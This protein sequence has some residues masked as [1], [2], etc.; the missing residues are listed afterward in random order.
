MDRGTSYLQRKECRPRRSDGFTYLGLIILVAIISIASA[1]TLQMGSVVQRRAAEEELL[2]I[3]DE[4]RNALISYANA[5]PA[6]QKRG[7]ASLQDLLKDPRYPN[8]KR[9]LRKLYADPITGKDQWGIVEAIDGS[10]IIGVH[11]LSEATP[12]KID[13]FESAFLDFA[14]KT[15][16]RD[17]RFIAFPQAIRQ[18]GIREAPLAR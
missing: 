5:T 4:F 10:G 11:S 18:G 7:P 1:A 15:S 8:P 16:Y 2:E 9:H 6:G 14:G 17:W 13:K 12:I 3:G